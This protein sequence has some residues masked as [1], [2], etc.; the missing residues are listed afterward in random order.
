[1]M[2][3]I[4]EGFDHQKGAIYGFGKNKSIDTVTDVVKICSLT[5][6]EEETLDGN[7][8]V[9]ILVEERIVGLVN[10]ELSI[11]GKSNLESV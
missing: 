9:H 3:M 1:M 10:H 7:A 8:Q 2:K 11:R 5:E 4:A 6:R